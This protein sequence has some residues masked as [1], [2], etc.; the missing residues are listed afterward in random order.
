MTTG[1]HSAAIYN[2]TLK[3]S[4]IGTVMSIPQSRCTNDPVVNCSAG[5]YPATESSCKTCTA[6]YYCPGGSYTVDKGIEKCPSGYTSNAG[7]TSQ[8]DC[9]I[10]CSTGYIAYPTATSCT[11]CS[12]G[13]YASTTKINY[14]SSSTCS[15]SINSD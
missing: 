6:G 11:T 2:W 7:A 4:C 15:K 10:T 3:S 1:F 5:S 8:T 14:G 13:Y 12:S 9:Y